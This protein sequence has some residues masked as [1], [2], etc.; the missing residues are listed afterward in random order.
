LVASRRLEASGQLGGGVDNR[1]VDYF[2]DRLDPVP[3]RHGE[4]S[5]LRQAEYMTRTVKVMIVINDN[6]W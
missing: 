2:D 1:D 6:K 4:K 3:L 5:P